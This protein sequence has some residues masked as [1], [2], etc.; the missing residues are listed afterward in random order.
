[1]ARH[2]DNWLGNIY[3][4]PRAED[5]TKIVAAEAAEHNA[6]VPDWQQ[7][8]DEWIRAREALRAIEL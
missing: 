4:E 3:A 8:L 1:L 5:Q 7:T 6:D 2:S